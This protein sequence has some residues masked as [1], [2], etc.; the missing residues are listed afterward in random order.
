MKTKK[1]IANVLAPVANKTAEK[2]ADRLACAFVFN[3]PKLP[4]KL[5]KKVK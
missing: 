4:A 2:T 1:I 5:M 3:Q